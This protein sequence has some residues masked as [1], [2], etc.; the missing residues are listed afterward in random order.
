MKKLIGGLVLSATLFAGGMS[1]EDAQGIYN[2]D[3]YGIHR[4]DGTPTAA[5]PEP[6]TWLMMASGVALVAAAK[7]RSGRR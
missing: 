6:G 7:W 4:H 3:H 1:K 2:Q 5:N